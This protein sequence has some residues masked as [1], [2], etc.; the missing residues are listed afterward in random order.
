MI[1][2]FLIPSLSTLNSYLKHIIQLAADY[3]LIISQRLY[4]V[5]VSLTEFLG[6]L[7]GEFAGAERF[8]LSTSLLTPN[9]PKI[10]PVL[11]PLSSYSNFSVCL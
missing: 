2:I 1:Y 10:N 5:F 3:I 6:L 7:W 4:A 9:Y 8:L 11:E